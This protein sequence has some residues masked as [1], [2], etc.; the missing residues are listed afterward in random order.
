MIHL[1]LT[2]AF[3]TLAITILGMTFISLVV[4]TKKKDEN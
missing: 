4:C 1:H 3:L 2:N